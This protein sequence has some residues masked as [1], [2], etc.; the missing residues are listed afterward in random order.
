M[1]DISPLFLNFLEATERLKQNN[2]NK[3]TNDREGKWKPTVL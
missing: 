3:S 2:N 1:Y